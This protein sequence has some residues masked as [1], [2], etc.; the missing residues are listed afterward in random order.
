M[1]RVGPLPLRAGALAASLLAATPAVAP[2]QDSAPGS[3]QDSARAW[4]FGVGERFTYQ[5]KLGIFSVGRATMAV[6][7][8]DSVR[9][10]ET[11]VLRFTL[12]GKALFFSLD[13][14][15]TS[16][17]GVRDFHSYRFLQDNNEDGRE[18]TK[19][20]KIFPDSGYYRVNQRDTTFSTVA[21][22]LDDTAFFYWV[23]TL[24][25]EVGQ[26][27]T[28]D[29]YFRPDQN[30]VRIRVLKRQNCELPGDIK[31]RCLL[32]Q[33]SIRAKGM[34]GESSDARIL[35]TDDVERIPV[36]VRSNFSFGTLVL[37]LREVRMADPSAA[38]GHTR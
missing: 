37:K 24:P 7:G 32:I 35:M 10:Q 3:M 34:L 30:P 14:T 17:T 33:P 22:P 6:L 18:R 21:D 25:L 29:R 13:D 4:P 8:R 11:F 19:D 1:I 31:R 36:E 38:L 20:Y 9:G 2:A 12:N 28:W 5:V 23:R 26:S 27:Y 16:W 15:L